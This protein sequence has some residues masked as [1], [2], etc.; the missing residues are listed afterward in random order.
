MKQTERYLRAATR[1]LWGRARRELQT[2]LQGHINERVAEFRLGGLSSEDAER[3]TLRELG[4]PVRVSG[5]MLGVHTV[6]ALGK[7]GALSLLL[8]TTLL[9]TLPQGLAQ[10]KSIYGS[11]EN[12]WPSSYLNFEQLM[13]SIKTAGGEL[14]G[15]PNAA[16][17]TV[18]DAPR[19]Q[20]P[21]NTA[22]W[23]GATLSQEGK[24]YLHTDLLVST[25]KNTGANV[26]VRGWTNP[27]LTAGATNIHLE[28]DDWRV[29]NDLYT[30]T[31]IMSG[32]KLNAGSVMNSLEPNGNTSDITFKG[33]FKKDAVYAFVTPVFGDWTSQKTGGELLNSGNII[34]KSNVNQ[35]KDGQVQ[36]RM[37]NEAKHFK[38]YSD[39]NAFQAALDPY[40]DTGKIHHWD[41]AHPAPALILELS[42]HFGPD[43][44]SVVPTQSVQRP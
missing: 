17:L 9:T 44:Y 23:K 34:L 25:L 40:R 4:T 1:G 28:T 18:P 7:A 10:V 21:L 15:P 43:A 6:P 42:G 29:L 38:L 5:G 11:V 35:A 27:T 19:S 41:A 26:R 16:T 36:F 37:D 31:L 30:L 12:M 2:E 39:V 24:T 20:Y 3:Q 33:T 13:D 14:S 22:Q 8:A 32:P